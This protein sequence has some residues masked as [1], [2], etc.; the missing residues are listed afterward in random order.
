MGLHPARPSFRLRGEQL[1]FRVAGAV[2]FGLRSQTISTCI[3]NVKFHLRA[4]AKV[5]SLKYEFL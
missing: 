5:F 4:L 3:W 2:Y 1:A